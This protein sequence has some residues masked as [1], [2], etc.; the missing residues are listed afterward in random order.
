MKGRVYIAPASGHVECS[1]HIWEHL[2]I[3]MQC[4]RQKINM[5]K[6]GCTSLSD[7]QRRNEIP[8]FYNYTNVC[9]RFASVNF[10]RRA[11]H[12]FAYNM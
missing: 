5:R 4:N 3:Q 6:V 12:L 1:G 9:A 10:N 8:D 2:H 11:L 7:A